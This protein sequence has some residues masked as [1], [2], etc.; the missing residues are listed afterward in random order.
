MRFVADFHI[1]SKY[2]RATSPKTDLEHLSE[3]AKVKGVKVL[4]TGDFT[5]P[6]WLKEMQ[7]KLTGAEP[8]LFKLKAGDNGTRFILSSEI[9][10]IYKKNDRVRKIH[11]L[12]LAPSFEAVEK[13]NAKLNAIGNLKS[14]GRPILGLDAKELAKIIF[15]ASADCMVVPAHCLLP[16]SYIH[17]K[18]GLKM[19]KDITKSDLVFTHNGRLRKVEKVYKRPYRGSIFHIQPFYFRLGLKTTPEHPF[20]A[21]K[22]QKYCPTMGCKTVCKQSCTSPKKEKCPHKYFK[23]YKP[24]WIQSQ[25]IERGDVLIFPRFNKILQKKKEIN[26]K[27]YLEK[28]SYQLKDGYLIFD[29]GTRCNVLPNIIKID[30]DF[31]RLIGYYLSEGYTD[32][33][34]SISFCFNEKEGSYTEDVKILM[35]KVFHLSYCREVKRK[36][37]KSVELIFFSKHLSFLF[38]K[39]FYQDKDD[40]KKAHTKCLPNWTLGLSTKQQAEIL[41][42]WW[43]GDTGYT[44]SRLLMNQMKIICLRLGIIPSIGVGHAREK[45]NLGEHRIGDRIIKSNHNVFHFSNLSFFEDELNLLQEDCFKK[46]NTKL[47]RK[48]G[49]IN[50]DNIYVPVRDVKKEDYSGEVYNLE[51]KDDN[52]YI[53]EFA[54]VHNC[55]TPWFSLFGSKSGFDKIEDCFEELTPQIFALETGLSSDPLMNWQ[56]SALD[57]FSLVSNSDCHSPEKIGREANVFDT[58]L[59][60]FA[61]GEAL[62]KKDKTKFLFTIEFFP[63]EG[64]YH[65]DG[66]RVCNVSFSPE[67]TKKH[68]GICPVCK[69]PL[70]VGVSNRVAELAD[71]TLGQK[72]KNAIPYKSIFPLRELIGEVFGVGPSSKKVDGEYQKLIKNCGSELDIL[73]EI[74]T[75][76]LK[77]KTLPDIATAISLMRQ[78]KVQAIPGYDGVYGKIKVLG[79]VTNSKKLGQ[80]KL[81]DNNF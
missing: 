15:E 25:N 33:R 20:Y 42:G 35:K 72:P 43:R 4:G 17:T 10:C 31:C 7:A 62:Q 81:F 16:E 67:Q 32:S 27:E 18:S 39:L 29:K 6:V 80:P 30:E 3:S 44:V 54:S 75:E 73:L 65:Y 55:W 58:D 36:N 1:H 40:V 74:P 21:I 63:E 50:K 22:S 78:G 56:L 47:K 2:S 37:R 24:Q 77:E 59:S 70:V 69:K 5:H 60:Y 68:N 41:K 26:L 9:S 51:V 11:I 14:D 79:G 53:T 66:H 13:I 49:W 52:S 64:K 34:D 23:D 76:K 71:R 8:G 48:H 57:R 19:I 61:I 38:G 28:G 45:F 12:T 46:F